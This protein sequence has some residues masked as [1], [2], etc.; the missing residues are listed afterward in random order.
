LWHTTSIAAAGAM[1]WKDW[2]MVA[3][4][5]VLLYLGVFKKIEPL[6]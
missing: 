6:L 5:L 2:I 1:Q 3:V 4:S